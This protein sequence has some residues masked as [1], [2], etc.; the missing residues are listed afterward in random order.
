M[1]NPEHKDKR[2]TRLHKEETAIKKQQK[3]AMQHGASRLDVEREPHRF[4]KHK[5]MDCGNPDCAMC[6]NPRHV[7]KHSETKQEKSFE[8][9]QKWIEE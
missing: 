9:T 4:A 5:A 2:S 3:I 7:H 8:Q 6:G 1:S